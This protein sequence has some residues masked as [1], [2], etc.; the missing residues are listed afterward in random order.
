MPADK[1][2][3]GNFRGA[4]GEVLILPFHLA[5]PD[6]SPK[7]ERDAAAI[8]EPPV[9]VRDPIAFA[10]SKISEKRFRDGHQQVTTMIADLRDRRRMILQRLWMGSVALTVVSGIVLAIGFA[11]GTIHDGAELDK[12]PRRATRAPPVDQLP[13]TAS[14]PVQIKSNQVKSNQLPD[15]QP[16]QPVNYEL[17]PGMA[18]I[19]AWLDGT[20]ADGDPAGPSDGDLHD[21]H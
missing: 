1:R 6:L 2:P 13:A 20:I 14:A 8:D 11:R 10:R 19:S 21:N 5:V 15:D 16:I 18:R 7:P 3:A 17:S 12:K 9:S 4:P